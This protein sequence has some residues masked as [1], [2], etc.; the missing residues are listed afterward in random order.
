[1]ILS[2]TF[3]SLIHLVSMLLISH[4]TLYSDY[5]KYI[6]KYFNMI[7]SLK[8]DI[9]TKFSPNIL[10][11]VIF[12]STISLQVTTFA[13]NYHVNTLLALFFDI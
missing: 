2:V 12:I 4:F 5:Q 11:S 1:M 8:F 7:L 10:N 3:Q 13:V 9:D 6:F